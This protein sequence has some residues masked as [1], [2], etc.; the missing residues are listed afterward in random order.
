MNADLHNLTHTTRGGTVTGIGG[1]RL[2]I[3]DPHSVREAESDT[4]RQRA[5]D[6]W[7][8]NS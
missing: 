3:D 8:A 6:V 1:T 5:I 4:Q 2:V 7:L